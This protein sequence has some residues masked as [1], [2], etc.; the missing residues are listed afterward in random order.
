MFIDARARSSAAICTVTSHYT[1]LV[2]VP[3]KKAPS[4]K[5]GLLQ[6]DGALRIFIT[7]AGVVYELHAFPQRP[8][9]TRLR[10]ISPDLGR[11]LVTCVTTHFL[12]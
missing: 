3:V 9:M 6:F 5:S 2:V 1:G 4:V 12:H 10:I 7:I 8:A 11:L